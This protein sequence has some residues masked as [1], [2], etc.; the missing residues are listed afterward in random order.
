LL[1]EVDITYGHRVTFDYWSLNTGMCRIPTKLRASQLMIVAY[2]TGS[3]RA[4]L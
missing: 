4:I 3:G 2:T 1:C